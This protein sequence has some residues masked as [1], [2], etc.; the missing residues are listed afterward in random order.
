[1]EVLTST[2]VASPAGIRDRSQLDVVLEAVSTLSLIRNAGWLNIKLPPAVHHPP[3]I[4]LMTRRSSP[5]TR[6]TPL[7]HRG[8]LN[9]VDIMPFLHHHPLQP[10]LTRHSPPPRHTATNHR[11]ITLEQRREGLTVQR[12]T[13][14]LRETFVQRG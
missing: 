11:D 6:N 9:V 10:S 4:L 7:L 12:E 3:L 1:M 14:P 5:P 8:A 13:Q 2:S